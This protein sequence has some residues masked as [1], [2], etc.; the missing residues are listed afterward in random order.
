MIL[1]TTLPNLG[2]TDGDEMDIF[3]I[4]HSKVGRRSEKLQHEIR[5]TKLSL[6]ETQIAL[7]KAI[8]KLHRLIESCLED[9]LTLN[10]ESCRNAGEVIEVLAIEN[11]WIDNLT[12]SATPQG[13]VVLRWESEME[14][15]FGVII[16]SD[17][18]LHY[19]GIMQH[20]EISGK[21]FFDDNSRL[22]SPLQDAIE[23]LTNTK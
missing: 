17:R 2:E 18:M 23:T 5:E 1:Y 16:G 4:S 22:P 3:S 7:N 15:T 8:E 14:G 21:S 6:V 13:E 12:F 10:V 11:K 20:Q 19:A 9:D